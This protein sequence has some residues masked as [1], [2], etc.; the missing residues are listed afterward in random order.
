MSKMCWAEHARINN[1]SLPNNQN[2]FIKLH[3]LSKLHDPQYCG[4]G[5][6]FCMSR[7]LVMNHITFVFFEGK[8]VKSFAQRH[9]S[10]DYL[11][12][13]P[14]WG[15]WVYRVLH[16]VGDTSGKQGTQGIAGVRIP[17][18]VKQSVF[19]CWFV[20]QCRRKGLWWWCDL[21]LLLYPA[22]PPNLYSRSGPGYLSPDRLQGAEYNPNPRPNNV[23]T[24]H[25]TWALSKV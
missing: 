2:L 1:W 20:L 19:S 6:Q 15:T 16:D 4:C 14:P 8:T 11:G 17:G 12:S 3:L 23:D 13:A 10:R 22:A 7:S 25:F 18:E 9:V 5:L 24:R 21:F